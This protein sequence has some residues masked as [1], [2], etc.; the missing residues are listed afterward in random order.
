MMFISFVLLPT[1]GLEDESPAQMVEVVKA[2][3][4]ISHIMK[5]LQMVTFVSKVLTHSLSGART[6]PDRPE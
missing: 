1:Q 2:V 5:F 6:I 4:F 3:L